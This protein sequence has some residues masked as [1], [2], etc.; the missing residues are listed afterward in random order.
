MLLTKSA[1]YLRYKMVAGV[2]RV[3]HSIVHVNEVS[4]VMASRRLPA[5]RRQR[6]PFSAQ[7]YLRFR[8]GHCHFS[9]PEWDGEPLEPEPCGK[10]GYHPCQCVKTSPQPCADCGKSACECPKEPCGGCGQRPCVCKKKSQVKVKLARRQR[11]DDSG[12]HIH[13]IVA[14]GWHTDV[15][16][17]VD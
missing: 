3:G 5:L 7:P 2:K 16:P 15:R 8:E 17:A 10:C 11:A 6:P 13:Q 9:D 4:S 1:V 12:H 14:S